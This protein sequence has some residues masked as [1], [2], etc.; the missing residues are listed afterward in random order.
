MTLT[1]QQTKLNDLY[2]KNFG[3]DVGWGEI[4]GGD[5]WIDTHNPQTD[6]DWDK[7]DAMLFGSDEGQKFAGNVDG[8][9]KGQVY[10]GG[11]DSTK[12]IASQSGTN[13]FWGDHF[14]DGGVFANMN[15]AAKAQAIADKI[16]FTPQEA[17]F[18]NSVGGAINTVVGGGGDD[19]IVG[20]GGED[21]VVTNGWWNQFEDADAFKAFLQG[22]QTQS[23]TGGM[24][25]FM[26]FMMLMS[27]MGGGRGGGMG[28]GSQ[29]GYGGLN[30]GGVQAAYNP[31]ENLQ[32][33]GDWFK[34]NFGS[35]GGAS[36]AT[37]NAT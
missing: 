12:S 35:G 19:T 31:L 22:D 27:V 32:G 29:Y 2:Q 13:G 4:G 3:R 14:K 20:G 28:G 16:E 1:A 7:V 33:M 36:T 23:S 24:D 34:N 11:I 26:K 10:V 15:A 21:G 6:E 18:N 37:A 9:N 17:Y 30:P 25:D 5:Y 8:Y